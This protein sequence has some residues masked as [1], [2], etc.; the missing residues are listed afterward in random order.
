MTPLRYAFLISALAAAGAANAHEVWVNAPAHLNA[1]STLDADLAYHHDFPNAEEIAADRLHI[2]PPMQLTAANGKSQTLVQQGK[3]YQYHSAKPLSKG[4][5]WVSASY[6]PTFWS[7]GP[8]GWKQG[9][10]KANPGSTYCEHSQMFG[11]S[12]LTVGQTEADAAFFSRPIGLNLEI[13]P[14]AN[15]NQAK[16][17]ELLPVQ[18]FYQG[19]PLAGAILTATADT[20]I[21]KDLA[22]T[23]DHREP[24]AFSAKTD[25]EGKVN[26]IPMMEGLWKIRVIYKTP[27]GD[28]SVCQDEVNYSTLIVPIGTQRRAANTDAHA[29]H[30]H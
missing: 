20:F 30:Q 17:G 12:L 28:S 6:R 21:E 7:Q 26:V 24:Q 4:S 16:V 22:A 11:K 10:M 15:P 19:K 3:N 8:Q 18:V 23:H 2:F 29:A 25:K 27:F 14:L 13:V 1:G 9:D 5:Y